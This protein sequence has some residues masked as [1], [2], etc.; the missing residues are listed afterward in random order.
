MKWLKNKLGQARISKALAN[1]EEEALYAQAALEVASRDI[2][3]GLWAK[4]TAAAEGDE[5]KAQARYLGLRVEQMQLQL[6]AAEE[7]ARVHSP[8][9]AGHWVEDEYDALKGKCPNCSEIIPLKSE[10]CPKCGALLGEGAAWEVLPIRA[11]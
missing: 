9:N 8:K 4:A 3:P 6:G 2:R 10:E 11:T 5:R 7:M 1:A